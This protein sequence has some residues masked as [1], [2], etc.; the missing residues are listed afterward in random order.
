EVF[1]SPSQR[2]SKVRG[3]YR[4]DSEASRRLVELAIQSGVC[5]ETTGSNPREA[6]EACRNL[7]V[8]LAG[9]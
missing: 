9:S 5:W 4:E 3:T 2:S 6:S 8:K 7:A 1:E